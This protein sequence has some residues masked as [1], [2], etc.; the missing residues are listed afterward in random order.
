MSQQ[1]EQATVLGLDNVPLDLPV[2]GAGNRALAAFLDYLLLAA[3]FALVAAGT[4]AAASLARMRG[5]WLLALVLLTF[6]VLEYGYFSGVEIATGGRSFGKWALGLR[7]ATRFGG[8][9]GVGA[10]LVRNL[11]RTVDLLFGV[12][13]MMLD[14][15][16]RRLGDRLAGTLVVHVPQRAEP[17]AELVLTRIPR[18]WGPR[19][20]ALLEAF[21]RRAPELEPARSAAM[22]QALLACIQR[23]DPGLLAGVQPA[24]DPVET[25]RRVLQPAAR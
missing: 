20:A 7:V 11:V 22:A 14:P 15:L 8:A 9:P 19:E 5:P 6:F 3:A 2:A 24:A 18:G 16:A 25:L 17:E 12:P 4:I 23:D 1:P 21:L 10:L 13:L